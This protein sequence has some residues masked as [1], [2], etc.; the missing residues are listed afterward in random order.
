M[1]Y[2]SVAGKYAFTHHV[3]KMLLENRIYV[4]PERKILDFGCGTGSHVYEFRDQGYDAFGFDMCNYVIFRDK[5]DEDFFRFQ[6]RSAA[7]R[8][9]THEVGWDFS[10]EA[11]FR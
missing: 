8:S 9:G 11:R 7:C 1:R 5:V 10:D 4:L 2:I 3:L 6:H